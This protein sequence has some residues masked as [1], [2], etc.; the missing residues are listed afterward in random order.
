MLSKYHGVLL[1][2]GAGVFMLASR[3]QRFWFATPWPYAAGLVAL[4][5]FS[6]VLVWNAQHGWVSFL[7]QGGRSGAPHLNLVA[8]FVS[9]RPAI[10]DTGAMDLHSARDAV[11]PRAVART[12]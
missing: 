8:P 5:V 12:G 11:R 7:F 10:P 1:F 9:D 6:P 2:A 4:L 3:R